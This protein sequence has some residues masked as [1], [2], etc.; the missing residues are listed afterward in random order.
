MVLTRLN[1]LRRCARNMD[2]NDENNGIYGNNKEC[3]QSNVKIVR[4]EHEED[5]IHMPRRLY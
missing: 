5:K 1:F 3:T 2:I 4:K